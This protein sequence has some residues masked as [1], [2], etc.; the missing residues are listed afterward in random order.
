MGGEMTASEASKRCDKAIRVLKTVE[1]LAATYGCGHFVGHREGLIGRYGAIFDLAY[2]L[3]SELDDDGVWRPDS[4][5][6]P[7]G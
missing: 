3:A 7:S 4:S 2:K 5:E 6:K 1:G